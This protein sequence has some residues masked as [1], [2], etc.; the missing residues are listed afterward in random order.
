MTPL[1]SRRA[2][3][4]AAIGSRAVWFG[5]CAAV[6]CIG[7]LPDHPTGRLAAHPVIGRLA[8][9]PAWQHEAVA[10]LCADFPYAAS[11]G[12]ACLRA[13]PAHEAS[14]QSLTR[15]ILADLPAAG[16]SPTCPETTRHGRACPGHLRTADRAGWPIAPDHLERM[17]G[18]GPATTGSARG[19]AQAIRQRNRDDF[20]TGRIV[21]IDGWMLSLTETRVYAL[22]ALSARTGDAA[23]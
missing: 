20:A 7:R 22:A 16:A 2:L 10:A 13:L 14:R 17:A 6:P 9:H 12:K 21:T 8:A 3:L 23:G 15:A 18:T 19:L 4:L 5:R 1:P 11:I